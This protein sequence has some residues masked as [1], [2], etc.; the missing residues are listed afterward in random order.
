MIALLLNLA[1]ILEN[2]K[3][4]SYGY[5][6]LNTRSYVQAPL[7][8]WPFI[9]RTAKQLYISTSQFRVM[10]QLSQL[11]IAV[12]CFTKKYAGA[13]AVVRYIYLIDLRYTIRLH[14]NVNDRLQ[15]VVA[16]AKYLFCFLQIISNSYQRR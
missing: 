5:S 4:G 9:D 11:T 1:K 6:A 10:Q 16:R 15:V 2:L 12:K 7:N 14:V 8:T 3:Q 13:P